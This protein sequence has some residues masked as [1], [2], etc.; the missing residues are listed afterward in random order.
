MCNQQKQSEQQLKQA[1][2]STKDKKAKEAIEKKL[3]DLGKEIK[4]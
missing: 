1:K 4:K 2:V 3:E